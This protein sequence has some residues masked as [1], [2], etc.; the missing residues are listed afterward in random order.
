MIDCMD[1]DKTFGMQ[2]C[3]EKLAV[4]VRLFARRMEVLNASGCDECCGEQVSPVQGHILFEIARVGMPSMQQVAEGLGVDITTFSRQVKGL[5][6]KGLVERQP[7]VDDRRVTLLVLTSLGAESLA[8]I[9]GFM[10][11]EISRILSGMT[12][13]EQETVTR[14][15]RLL[16]DV[17]VR[18]GLCC[19]P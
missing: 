10:S 9:N 13:F 4:Q 7:S 2:E 15:L 14:S 18:G 11:S 16:N 19:G 12:P 17:M 6:E 1:A 8:R 3:S 5:V